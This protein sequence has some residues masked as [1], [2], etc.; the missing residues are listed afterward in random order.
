MKFETTHSGKILTLVDASVLERKQLSLSL[1]KKL[2]YYNFLPPA[3]KKRWNGIVSYFHKDRFVPVGLWQELKYIAETFKFPLEI[4]GLG[5]AIFYKDVTRDEF[6][7]WVDDKF[8]GAVNS[9]GDDFI[10][11]KYQVDTAYAILTNK[12]SVSELTTAAGKS[13]I[14]FICIVYFQETGL[15]KKFLMIVPSIDLVIQAYEDFNEYNSFLLEDN[16][17]PLN[18]KQIH[19]GEKKDFIASQNI[20]VS[21]FQS[22]AKFQNQYF[23]VFDTVI[24]D[25]CLHPDSLIKMGDNTT[26]KISDVVIGDEVWTTNDITG[27]LEINKVDYI[28]K[29]L[30]SHEHLYELELEDGSILELTGN[31]KVKLSDKS[32]KRVDELTGSEDIITY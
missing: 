28:Y 15:G 20:H 8:F 25:E 29:N 12:I 31:H 1:T 18:I 11:R 17:F 7:D 19:G 24:V 22:L 27:D 2:E 6:Q 14:I 21:T 4:T 16:R 26:K 10:P 23:T 5:E 13:L 9:K 30:S 32:Y 3:V